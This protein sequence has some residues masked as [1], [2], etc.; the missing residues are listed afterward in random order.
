MNITISPADL[1]APE[2]AELVAAHALFCDQTAPPD[3]CHRLPLAALAQD[4]ITVWK[5]VLDGNLMGMGALKELS[6]SKGEIKSMH[7]LSS[8]RGLGVGN[9]ILATILNEAKS[10]GY[11]SLW[12]E[13]GVHP[14]FSAAHKLY[15]AH[16]FV[17]C[18][19]FDIYQL[20]PHSMFMTLNLKPVEMEV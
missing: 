12:L 5:A 8:S 11:A 6:K 4:D 7:T 14:D 2:F 3:S 13:T 9:L 1:D 15:E 10:R 17:E 16:G 20:D 19:P 18:G